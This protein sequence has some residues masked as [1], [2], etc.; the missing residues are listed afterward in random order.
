MSN[1]APFFKKGK[2][3]M[4]EK[5]KELVTVRLKGFGIEL[6]EADSPMLAYVIDMVE[7]DIKNFCHIN[8]VPEE[9]YYT[10]SEAVCSDFLRSKL[11]TGSL[12]NISS[13]VKSIA[14]G[15]T[16]VT[17]SESA[18]PEAQLLACLDAM[19]LNL[20]NLVRFRKLVW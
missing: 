6:V 3:S 9:L 8:E 13:I 4:N 17:F 1:L 16:T 12:E 7:R 15:D 19:K 2:I 18:T 5:I 14:E 10:W 20:S 11:S